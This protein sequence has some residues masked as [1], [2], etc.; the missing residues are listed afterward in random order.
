[1][2]NLQETLLFPVR[3]SQSRGQSMFAAFLVPIT[4]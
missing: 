4:A 3:D 2:T 1:M